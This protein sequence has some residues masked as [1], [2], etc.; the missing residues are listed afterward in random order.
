MLKLGQNV[1][2][3]WKSW[4]LNKWVTW[5]QKQGQIFN[6][7][8]HTY[9]KQ[10]RADAADPSQWTKAQP[11]LV[12]P[13]GKPGFEGPVIELIGIHSVSAAETFTQALMGRRPQVLRVG[14]NTQGVFSDVLQRQLPNGWKFGL[15][16]ER[17]ITDG[18]SY[19]GPG[20]PPDIKVPVFSANDLESG[21]DSAIE[22]ALALLADG[23]WA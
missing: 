20:I 9:S 1:S 13:S 2:P 4:T 7:W 12:S 15:P 3:W 23:Q 8:D 5:S 22:K 11:S 21:I 14:E 16:N 17:F 19:D 6:S 10:A 18:K